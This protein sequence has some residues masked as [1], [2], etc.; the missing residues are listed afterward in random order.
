MS[1]NIR[2]FNLGLKEFEDEIP[3]Y[4]GQLHRAVMLEGL[5]GVVQMTP[6]DTGRARGNWQVTMATPALGEVDA[7]DKRGAATIAKGGQ[8]IQQVQ[9]YSV[10]WIANNLPYI[11]ELEG[12]S[13]KQA[14]AGMLNV[15]FTR[16]QSWLAR[17]R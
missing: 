2:E 4:V 3:K 13:S 14:P 5:K 1:S 9:P 12:G 11:E 7:E 6:V 15:T 17:Q 10:S 16:L 8:A